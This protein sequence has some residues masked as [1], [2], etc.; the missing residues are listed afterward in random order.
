MFR[1]LVSPNRKEK[2]W[3]DALRVGGG[4]KSMILLGDVLV[5][6]ELW[7]KINGFPPNF[8]EKKKIEKPKK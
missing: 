1:V 3:P 2:G 6:Y 4:A 5:G 8:Y 7:R